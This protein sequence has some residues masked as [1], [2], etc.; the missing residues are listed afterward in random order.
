M[1]KIGLVG[2]GYMGG[3]H[4]NCYAAIEGVRVTAVADVRPEFL[5][6][7]AAQAGAEAY[8]DAAGLIENADVDMIDICLPTFLHTE[9]ALRAMEKGRHVFIEKPVCLTNGDA[10]LLLKKQAET[11][12]F[13][14]VGQVIRFWDEYKYLKNIVDQKV[15]G[16]VTGAR[17]LRHS[18]S[19]DWGWDNWLHD[20]ARSGGAGMDLHIHDSDYMLY[21]FGEPVSS[22]SRKNVLG[23]QNS[24]V[25][26]L[27]DYGDFSVIVEGGWAFP[28]NYPFE[29]AYT[30][31]FERAT[32]T[33]S[34]VY[35]LH[36]YPAEGQAFEPQIERQKRVSS[37]DQGGNIASLGGYY[38]E[39]LYF[40]RCIQENAVPSVAT[41]EQAARSVR[42]VL[43]EL[44]S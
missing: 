37:S 10:D 34:S 31:S 42:F 29:M 9:Y 4:L 5:K 18:P 7:A 1:L 17:F 25:V 14:Q 38:N 27:A 23:E 43:E 24:Y 32:V 28:V 16:R 30:V 36:V 2:C 3:M 6:K 22:V 40:I 12:V 11:G 13:V 44:K 35:G 33:F 15:Y 39:L 8:T 26:T 21:L 20:P 19:P 41:L